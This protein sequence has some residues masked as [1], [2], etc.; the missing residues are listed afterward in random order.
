MS[1]RHC[2][3]GAVLGIALCAH[4][5]AGRQVR[6]TA[7]ALGAAALRDTQDPIE[8]ERLSG[9]TL[10]IEGTVA[11]GRW[12]VDARY[13]EGSLSP[14]VGSLARD[15]VEGEL[16]LGYQAL[17]WLDVKLGP[18]IRSY[19]AGGDTERWVFWE[20]RTQAE[21]GLYTPSTE[22]F[23]L[24]SYVELWLVL[25]GTVNLPNPYGSGRGAEGGMLLRLD[26][27]P[28]WARFAYRVDRGT[29]QEGIR[30]ETLE[31]IVIAIGITR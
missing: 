9:V 22:R 5:L 23:T 26:R 1:S 12:F 10:G 16:L 2:L 29:L 3:L 21:W 27:A 20:A 24:S 7:G 31:Q 13:L 25:T 17:D 4:P 11:R 15:V 8:N 28:V 18:H 6:F 14:S 30:T 19:L